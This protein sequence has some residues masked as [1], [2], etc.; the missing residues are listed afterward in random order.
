VGL[1]AVGGGP[2][3]AIWVTAPLIFGTIFGEAWS[4]AGEIV[5]ILAVMYW[6]QII[7]SPTSQ[8]LNALGKQHLQLMW[9]VARA[10]VVGLVFGLSVALSWSFEETLTWLV[11]VTVL[12]YGILLV[13]GYIALGESHL[14]KEHR[15]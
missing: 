3:V 8:T 2:A 5:R 4:G 14:P 9:D 10:L 6:A 15:R 11:V 13:G 1:A 7:A 12:A